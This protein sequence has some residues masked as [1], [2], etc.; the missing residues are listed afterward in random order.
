MAKPTIAAIE[1]AIRAHLATISVHDG[2]TLTDWV[3][4]AATYIPEYDDDATGY[5]NLRRYGQPIHAT[6]GLLAN[7]REDLLTNALASKIEED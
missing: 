2:E 1:D 3:V 7:A 5:L 4:A 6:I